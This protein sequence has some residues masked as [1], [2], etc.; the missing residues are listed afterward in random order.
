MRASHCGL[1]ME[2][3][4]PVGMSRLAA[5]EIRYAEL[6]RFH[7]SMLVVVDFRAHIGG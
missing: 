5:M 1:R 2:I 7:K 4:P 3:D 6:G